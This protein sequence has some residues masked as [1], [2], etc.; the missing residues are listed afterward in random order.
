MAGHLKLKG[1]I[2]AVGL[3]G[4]GHFVGGFDVQRFSYVF[5]FLLLPWL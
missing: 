1:M 4:A 5:L 2:Q 3:A